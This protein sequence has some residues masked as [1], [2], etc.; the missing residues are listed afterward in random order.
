MQIENYE[1]TQ[2][3]KIELDVYIRDDDIVNRSR[4]HLRRMSGVA[5]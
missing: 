4:S 2:T 5:A 1:T 3:F